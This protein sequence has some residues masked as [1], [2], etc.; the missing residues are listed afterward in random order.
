MPLLACKIQLPYVNESDL[1]QSGVTDLL[2]LTSRKT[3][4]LLLLLSFH[5]IFPLQ[6]SQRLE[7]LEGFR[8]ISD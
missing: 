1:C 4:V 7:E 6:G 3:V 8:G 5:S 2:K